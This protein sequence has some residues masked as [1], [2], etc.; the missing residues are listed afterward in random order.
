M[1]DDARD[2]LV[3]R[4]GQTIKVAASELVHERLLPADMAEDA[5]RDAASFVARGGRA[6]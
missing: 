1:R 3:A 4:Y 5:A 6:R 2:L